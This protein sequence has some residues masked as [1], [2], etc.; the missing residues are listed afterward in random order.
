MVAAAGPIATASRAATR[1]S[2]V[3]DRAG[4]D[5]DGLHEVRRV[6]GRRADDLGDSALAVH[7]AV[8][9]FRASSTDFVPPLPPHLARG[10][11]LADRLDQLGRQVE[12]C[13]D[14]L[15]AADRW[16][17]VA[18]ASWVA[19]R[20]GEHATATDARTATVEYWQRWRRSTLVGEDPGAVVHQRFVDP[21]VDAHFSGAAWRAQL[22]D[23]R[24]DLRRLVGRGQGAF[25]P[26]GGSGHWSRAV[27]RFGASRAGA[28]TRLGGRA[29]G[30][31]GVAMGAVDVYE[32]ARAGDEER[33]ATGALSA[34]A[35]IAV[36]S[37]FPP[38]Q[39]AGAVV[40]GGLLV[41]EYRAEIADRTRAVGRGALAAAEAA[42][43]FV[44]GLF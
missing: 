42:A 31:A 36:M 17:G 8:E 27:D 32:G 40:A 30:V 7:R 39:L 2:T 15:V 18:A 6:L 11:G 23:S 10:V 12:R 28:V 26:G 33:M 43:R 21:E 41:Y 5:L 34:A 13:R 44:D 25:S 16:A 38:A 1:G 14:A 35:G 19:D 20:Q 29:L 4:A 22:T 9:A 37:G 3:T 24:H